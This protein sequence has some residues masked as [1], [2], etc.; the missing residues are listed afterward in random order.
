MRR[1]LC[2]IMLI[3]PMA[4]DEEA[5]PP[6]YGVYS[7][8]GVLM[9]VAG[10][11]PTETGTMA[12][13]L[14]LARAAYSGPLSRPDFLTTPSVPN[15]LA[16]TFTREVRPGGNAIDGGSLTF[17]Y[18]VPSGFQVFN[19][20]QEQARLAQILPLILT[21]REEQIPQALRNRV[22][23][24]LNSPAVCN[25]VD[26]DF[27]SPG[28]TGLRHEC[29]LTSLPGYFGA[30]YSVLGQGASV[31]ISSSGGSQAGAFSVGPLSPPAGI[32]T[33]G[34]FNLF[35]VDPRGPVLVQWT[36]LDRLDQ[37]AVIEIIATA[38]QSGNGVQILCIEPITAGQR[39]IPQGAL[40]LV[41]ALQ[42]GEALSVVTSIAAVQFETS[43]EG[44]GSYN[45]GV[46]RGLF[47]LSTWV[48]E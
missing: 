11:F 41:P 1:L 34:S 30:P 38:S 29:N 46:G 2:L 12:A 21:G 6:A 8:S 45:I 32:Q 18:S 7:V 48:Q 13:G 20:E 31:T 42:S 24:D 37:V 23:D 5:N 17:N 4:C 33:T 26:D 15:C 43:D 47:G 19:V 39:Q 28:E 14:V 27:S 16:N 35:N 44:W 25:Q 10:V 40:D 9:D 22:E 36:P 3:A